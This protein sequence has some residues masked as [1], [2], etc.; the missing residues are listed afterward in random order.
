MVRIKFDSRESVD[1]ARRI[2]KGGK[3]KG[4]SERSGVL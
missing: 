1:G 3:E 2:S 4:K